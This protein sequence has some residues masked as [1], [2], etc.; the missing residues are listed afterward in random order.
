MTRESE[1]DIPSGLQEWLDATSDPYVVQRTLKETPGE[2]TQIVY[3]RDTTG[4]PS[5][6]PFV[7]K[8]FLDSNGLGNAYERLLA[9][10]TAGLRLSHAPLVYTCDH[11]ADGTFAVVTEYVHGETLHDLV[12]RVGPGP[13]VA[14]R[15]MPLVCEAASELHELPGQ[16]VIHRDI[17]PSN[18]MVAEDRVVL[19]DLGIARS[20]REDATRDTVQY[21][22]PGYAPPE[23][24]GY[25][26]TDARSDVYALGMTLSFCLTGEEPTARLREGG[27]DDPRIPPA[28]RETIVRATQLDPTRRHASAQ[29]LKDD[30]VR[31]G[32][33][34]PAPEDP[35]R[36]SSPD[37]IAT[38]Q[39][40]TP[41]AA[42]HRFSGLGIIW[43]ALVMVAWGIIFV[44][45]VGATAQPG[46]ST[47][48]YDTWFRA[49]AYLGFVDVP[50]SAIAYL[51]L[52][53]RR[54]RER[55]HPIAHLTWRVELPFCLLL[56]FA[57]VLLTTIVG[58]VSG[59]MAST[60][61]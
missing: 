19:I 8:I 31:L 23:Q 6:G 2:T 9:A 51:L 53:K 40:T 48:S 7:R 3:R 42:S 59:Q 35:A 28:L 27:F 37:G 21:G 17:K 20:Y 50:V 15:V 34:E 41:P 60:G 12:Q 22:T 13:D 30:L 24:F 45:S 32:Q 16:P 1:P 26:Q 58:L 55:L 5:I 18:V 54:L 25:G 39:Q 36:A 29:E 43:N 10:Q 38:P 11:E 46:Q 14:L 57:S 44:A 52:D 56:V 33:G 61:Q 47:A 49:F 4:A